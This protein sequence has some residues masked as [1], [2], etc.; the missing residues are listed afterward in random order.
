[1]TKRAFTTE[2]VKEVCEM[3]TSGQSSGEIARKF[4]IWDTTVRDCLR[5]SGV[6]IRNKKWTSNE[7][8]KE[9]A[10][11]YTAGFS[12]PEIA[13]HV[14]RHVATV[15]RVVQKM[16]V[17]IRPPEQHHRKDF[18]KEDVFDTLTPESAYWIGM[19]MAD[20][21]VGATSASFTVT[22]SLH[23]RDLDHV[24]AF[25]KFLGSVCAVKVHESGGSPMATFVVTS[26]RLGESL[27]RYGVVPRK[28][29]IAV[30]RGGVEN[31]RDFWRGVI[32]GDGSLGIY[33]RKNLELPVP[34]LSLV[35]MSR[36]FVEQFSSFL[37]ARGLG[38]KNKILA[39]PTPSGRNRYDLRLGGSAA[40]DAISY[41]YVD[42][43]VVLARKAKL[44]S[45]VMQ[46][47]AAGLLV[48][49]R[50]RRSTSEPCSVEKGVDSCLD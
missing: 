6:E 5:K 50:E 40:I 42:A 14:N 25:R 16:G 19:L 17:A 34:V 13:E 48:G 27:S 29:L 21:C 37:H 49:S 38:G 1:M 10:E 47:T 2:Q 3:Y 20:G 24:L 12:C 11:L 9:V 45:R 41:L 4:G 46:M 44:A 18:L 36:E 39:Y 7:W 35:S 8:Q 26:K 28:S 31:S 43:A 23:S 33:A 22:L 32:D 15:W 30:A